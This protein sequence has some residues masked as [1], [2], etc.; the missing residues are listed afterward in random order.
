MSD[1]VTLSALSEAR[2]GVFTAAEARACGFT[3]YAIRREVLAVRWKRLDHGVYVETARWQRLGPLQ[4]HQAKL[5]A[6]LIVH[7]VGWCAARRSAALVHGLPCLGKPPEHPLLVRDRVAP[8]DRGSL[9]HERV[10]PLPSCDRTV[11]GGL[12]VTSLARTVVDVARAETFRSGVVTADAALRRGLSVHDLHDV[13]TRCAGWPG[14]RKAQAVV[15]FADKRAE[16][17]LESVSRVAFHVL[18]VQA[19]V[20]QV[21]IWDA[22]TFV[23]RADFL[24]E[25]QR[26]VG[27]ADGR[28]KYATADDFYREKLREQALRDLGFE[29]VRWDWGA[30][31]R[32]VGA[33]DVKLRRAFARGER[34][35]LDAAV[36]LVA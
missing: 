15:A 17:P 22:G 28:G 12:L 10:S 16:T 3:S 9:R 31:W 33:L 29:V 6:R 8:T 27:E 25:A 1:L 19:P 5:F 26:V 36:R 30:A 11:V 14:I 32:P 34:L 7:E 35:H 13:L 20:P 21:E 4:K 24:W 2:A 18:G 23:A